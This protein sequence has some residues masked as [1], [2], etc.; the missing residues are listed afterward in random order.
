[1]ASFLPAFV[2]TILR[3]VSRWLGLRLGLGLSLLVAHPVATLAQMPPVRLYTAD[4]GLPQS[5][6]Y[7]LGLDRWGRL[8]MGNQAGVC[9][10]NG[11]EF[12]SYGGAEGLADSYVWAVAPA[13]DGPTVWLGQLY[14][15]LAALGADERIRPVRL[16]GLRLPS[17]LTAL[18]AGPG[19]VWAGTDGQGLW[20]LRYA[21]G[22]PDTLVRH[23]GTAQGLPTDS[24]TSVGPGL[25][26]QQW[27][28]TPRGLAVLPTDGGSLLPT[29]Q[30]A[31]PAA[32]RTGPVAGFW[33][34][35][36][37][38]AWVATRHGL[39]RV[40]APAGGGAWRVRRYT[41]AQGLCANAVRSVVQDAAGRV[42]ANTAVG[43]CQGV[44]GSGAGAGA[45]ELRF[46]CLA[47][48]ESFEGGE[49]RDVL[50]DREGNL[51][52]TSADG[53]R[54]YLTNERFTQLTTRDGLLN[55]RLYAIIQPRPTELWLGV[56]GGISILPLGPDGPQPPARR[57]AV[58]TRDGRENEVISLLSDRRGL[59]WAGM[60]RD[61]ARRY[62]PRT[63][64]WQLLDRVPGLAGQ[65]VASI[66]EDRRG[67]VWLVT[68]RRGVTV[69]DPAAGT[70]RTFRRGENGLPS[71]KFWQ[72]YCDRAGRLWLASDDAGLL[73]VDT[74]RDT[75]RRVDGLPGLLSLGSI[76][77]DRAGDL[78]LGPVS[79]GLM[80]YEPATGRLHRYGPAVGQLSTNPFFVQADSSGRVWVGT[81]LGVDEF[82]PR[83]GRTRSY[84][85]AEGF[86]GGET[87]QNAVLLDPVGRLWMGT[88]GGLMLYDARRPARPPA[89]PPAA[90]T[91]LRVGLRDTALVAGMRLP[92]R[93]NNLSFDFLAVSLAQP[94]H[95]RYQYRLR[96]LSDEWGG[97][98][99]KPGCH[100]RQ[101]LARSLHV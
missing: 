51:W 48:P 22:R 81:N 93:L 40:S 66:G 28:A 9:V 85:R 95:V 83:A 18:W 17:N 23:W 19:E 84:G 69:Y 64:R 86:G 2:R 70:F 72:V 49:A 52:A 90:L 10:F 41:T 4:N 65:T 11:V 39:L 55:N 63:G 60:I 13:P 36:D 3:R 74:D 27:V 56:R 54:Q 12:K 25:R 24:V 35:S 71:D 47:R 31:L 6:V 78:W 75:F 5:V 1:M 43:L 88:V 73:A 59:V 20:Q 50:L 46:R 100:L 57:L 67:R 92:A 79:A 14:A 62:D 98:G 80:R 37:S 7:C 94:G 82:D 77:E 16:P 97:A 53:L 99:E 33:R 26:G 44:P 42:W 101:P 68:H 58:P 96:G 29:A 15:G 34:V 30:A 87:N 38:V 89:P 61:G 8:W 32:L 91:G 45:G 21:P 76:S